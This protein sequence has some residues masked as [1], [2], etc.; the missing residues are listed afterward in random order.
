MLDSI[1]LRLTL[2]YTVVL[3][4]VIG[5]LCSAA[6]FIFWRNAVKRTD[7]NLAELAES[8]LVTL[9][10]ELEDQN[11]TD[12]FQSAAQVAMDEHHF[13]DTLYAI[14]DQSGKVILTSLETPSANPP[15]RAARKVLASDSFQSFLAASSR[16]DRLFSHIPVTEAGYRGYAQHFAARGKTYILMI[17]QSLHPQN[18]MMAE[19]GSVFAWLIPIAILL[20]SGGGYFLAR[21]SLAPVVAM[22]SQAGRIGAANLHERLAVQNEKDELGHLARSFNGLLDRLGESFDRQRRFMADASHE[23]RTPVAILRGESEVALSQQARSS[24][25]YRESLSVLHHEAERLTRIVEDLFTLTRADAGQYPLQHS[26]FYLDELIAEC[27]HSARTLAQAK[28]ISLTF[29]GAPESPIHADESLLRRMLLNLLD[30]AIKYTPECGRITVAC[31]RNGK[32]YGV[33]ISD[34]GSGIPAELRPRIFERFF[35]VDKA[36]SRSENDGGGAGLGLAISR[37]I[38]EAHLGRLELTRSDS[39]G[40]T[41]TAYLPADSEPAASLS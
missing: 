1:R 40:S 28:K 29:E 17:L 18:Q 27:V 37:W 39:T 21:K 31:Q 6:Y 4:L 22:S 16:S 3:A 13:R 2:W 32:E 34:T 15:S 26:D 14:A 11:G 24:E 23:L 35:R 41:F 9:R 30:N 36:R 19:A 5:I 10:A 8:F 20:A 33:S 38:A 12:V 7:A 25:E